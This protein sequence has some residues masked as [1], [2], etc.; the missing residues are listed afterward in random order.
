VVHHRGAGFIAGGFK[1][2]QHTLL[3]CERL[4]FALGDSLVIDLVRALR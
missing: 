1:R 3:L 4:L 2:Q